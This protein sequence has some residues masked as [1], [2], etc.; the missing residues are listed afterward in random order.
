MQ[1][2]LLAFFVWYVLFLD[3][4]EYHKIYFNG[5][6]L[7]CHFVIYFDKRNSYSYCFST[8]KNILKINKILS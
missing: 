2:L 4:F 3:F 8:P 7:V 1:G 6:F 5:I